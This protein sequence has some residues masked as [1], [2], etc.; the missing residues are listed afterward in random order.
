MARAKKVTIADVAARAGV[1][2]GTVSHFLSG[3]QVSSRLKE[4]VTEAIAE[5][6]YVPNFHAQGLRLSESKVVGLC[7]PTSATT[8]LA[9]LSAGFEQVAKASGYGVLNVFSWQSPENEFQRVREMV[10]FRVDGLILFPSSSPGKTLDF[11]IEHKL[12]AVL[13][14]HSKDERFD[15]VVLENEE[16]S[17]SICEH[18]FRLGHRRILMV[19]RSLKFAVAQQRML[20]LK[21][22]KAQLGG[23]MDIRCLQFRDN[24]GALLAKL[25]PTLRAPSAPTAIVTSNSHQSAV[26]CGALQDLGIDCPGQVSVIGFDDPDWSTLVT[27]RLSVVRQPAGRIVDLAWRQ[28]LRRLEGFDGPPVRQTL[29]TEIVYRSSIGPARKLLSTGPATH[30]KAVA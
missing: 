19:C 12:P 1:S 9:S 17:R 28:I 14:D 4:R 11:I 30:S 20:G 25:G 15:Q 29:D 24:E 13:I 16:A 22:A 26:I 5:L 27:P 7:L 2:I 18:L 23:E 8:Y 21:M 10:R 3:R 6:G